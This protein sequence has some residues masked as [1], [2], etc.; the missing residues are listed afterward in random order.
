MGLFDRFKKSGGSKIKDKIW[1]SIAAKQ[2]ACIKMANTKPDLVF[3][4]W[5]PITFEKYASMLDRERVL[6]VENI[7]PSR[8]SNVEV[9]FLEHHYRQ[10]DEDELIKMLNLKEAL[11]LSSLDDPLFTLFKSDKIKEVLN[12]MNH[13][14]DEPVE[15]ELITKSMKRAQK[16]LLEIGVS[17]QGALKDWFDSL[18]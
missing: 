15:H 6:L 17:D 2:R 11:F 8:L 9:V 18:N 16:K 12:K 5:S 7:I 1:I 10:S 13:D 3:I 4:C 14:E